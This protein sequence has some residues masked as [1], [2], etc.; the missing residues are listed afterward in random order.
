M[1]LD[2]NH[3]CDAHM[4]VCEDIEA[5]LTKPD[6]VHAVIS[7]GN[8]KEAEVAQALAEKYPHI[9]AS[10][11]VHPWQASQERYDEMLPWLENADIVG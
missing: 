2:D 5:L 6:R 3:Y 4:H 11:G 10:Y 9:H 7:A 8:S 1:L